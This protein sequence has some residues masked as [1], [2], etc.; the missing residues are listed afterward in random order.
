MLKSQEGTLA[1]LRVHRT[2]GLKWECEGDS[3]FSLCRDTRQGGSVVMSQELL[4]EE[5]HL[6]PPQLM[7]YLLSTPSSTPHPRF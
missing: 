6:V 5:K 1:E 2:A 7:G 4:V 3:L